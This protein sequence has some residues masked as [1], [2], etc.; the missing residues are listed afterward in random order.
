[1]VDSTDRE[2]LSTTKEELH[3]MLRHEARKTMC[4]WQH[5]KVN[6]LLLLLAEAILF[7]KRMGTLCDEGF[8]PVTTRNDEM[9]R[10]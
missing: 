4:I 10:Y 7:L 5:L 1:M 6:P 8:K 3:K 9:F 2:R